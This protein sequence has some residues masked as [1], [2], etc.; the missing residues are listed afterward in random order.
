L[1]DT[2]ASAEL[3]RRLMALQRQRV[4]ETQLLDQRARRVLHDDVLP[5]LHAAMLALSATHPPWSATG[6]IVPEAK[7]SGGA[8]VGVRSTTSRIKSS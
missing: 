7:R 3:A 4:A 5:Q 1:I 8:G 2:R 6:T